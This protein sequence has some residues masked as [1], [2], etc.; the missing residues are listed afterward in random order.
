[1]DQS[2]GWYQEEQEGQAK[3]TWSNIWETELEYQQ[4]LQ[5]QAVA[6]GQS[7]L[8]SNESSGGGQQATMTTSGS[9]NNLLNGNTTFNPTRRKATNDNNKASTYNMNKYTTRL[10]GKHGGCPW[11]PPNHNYS[12]GILG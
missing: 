7:E 11:R 1:M 6:N 12:R 5:Q 8:K 3:Q 9:V 2:I 10:V 4:T